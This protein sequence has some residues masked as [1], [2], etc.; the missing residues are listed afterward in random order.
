MFLNKCQNTNENSVYK[1]LIGPF[2]I[3]FFDHTSARYFSDKYLHND[4]R[5][6]SDFSEIS[7]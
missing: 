4:S 2:I 5:N 1:I 7:L 3:N 6:Q